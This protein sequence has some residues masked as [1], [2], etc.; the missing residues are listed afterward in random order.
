AG[1]L[2]RA[3]GALRPGLLAAIQRRARERLE[4]VW[5]LAE[6]VHP[7]R[8]LKRGFARIEDRAGRLLAGAAAAR[9]AKRFRLVFADG[10]IDARSEAGVE[11]AAKPS[12]SKGKDEQPRLL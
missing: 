12:Y 2:G 9:A 8:P 6:A 5:R 11:R 10:A 7:D 3:A 1:E 4:A